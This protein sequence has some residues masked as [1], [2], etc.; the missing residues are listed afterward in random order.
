MEFLSRYP[1]L[2]IKK[3]F[4]TETREELEAK[5]NA[6]F[7][8]VLN[9]KKSKEIAINLLEAEANICRI[10]IN[11]PQADDLQLHPMF[12]VKR[13]CDFFVSSPLV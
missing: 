12:F 7:D 3:F 8:D 9:L 11:L 10:I 6:L 4:T 2:N 13:Y 1:T 5:A